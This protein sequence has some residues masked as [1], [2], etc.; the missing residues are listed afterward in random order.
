MFVYLLSFAN[1]SIDCNRRS[2]FSRRW[3]IRSSFV[4]I[5]CMSVVELVGSFG[6]AGRNGSCA[7]SSRTR[8]AGNPGSSFSMPRSDTVSGTLSFLRL[9]KSRMATFQ[10]AYKLLNIKMFGNGKKRAGDAGED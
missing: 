7:I 10:K 1:C 9:R 3:L 8:D 4:L 2:M 6:N 5:S